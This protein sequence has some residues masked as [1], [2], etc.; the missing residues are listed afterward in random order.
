MR[1]WRVNYRTPE[2]YYS[3][4]AREHIIGNWVQEPVVGHQYSRLM[5]IGS[6]PWM[7]HSGIRYRYNPKEKCRYDLVD[8]EGLRTDTTLNEGDCDATYDRCAELRDRNNYLARGARFF[9]AERVGSRYANRGGTRYGPQPPRPRD[10]SVPLIPVSRELI[11]GYRRAYNDAV[12]GYLG[13]CRVALEQNNP[14]GCRYSVFVGRHQYAGNQRVCSTPES[15]RVLACNV[16]T[17][18]QVVTGC[19][20]S[21]AASNRVCY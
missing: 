19:I 3:R 8:R 2:A 12:Q 5:V 9:C 11:E 4:V 14:A 13:Q 1:R 15:A 7:V 6:Y 18:Q 10:R 20:L 21:H 17:D 16:S